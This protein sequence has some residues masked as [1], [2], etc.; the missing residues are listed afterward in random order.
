M[1]STRLRALL[2]IVAVAACS[3]LL[4]YGQPPAIAAPASDGQGYLDSTARCP[5]SSTAVF[6]GSTANSRVAICKS[7]DGSFQYRGVRVSDGAKLIIAAKPSGNGYTA[8]NNGISY[9]LDSSFLTVASGGQ[10]VRNEAWVDYHGST[11][12]RGSAGSSAS[13]ATTSSS[14]TASPTEATATATVTVTATTP[15]K[16]LPPPL[17]AEVGGSGTR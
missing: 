3:A 11:S 7:S 5:S 10:T 1:L 8:V 6:F 15:A 4:A 2:L 13:S 9:S 14:T 12:P 17:P 16:P